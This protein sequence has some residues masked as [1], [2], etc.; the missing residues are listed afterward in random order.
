MPQLKKRAM[1]LA[2]R[3]YSS[4]SKTILVRKTLSRAKDEFAVD[5][6]LKAE[7]AVFVRHPW[8]EPDAGNDG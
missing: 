7:G 3:G 5:T 8:V 4:V 1:K 6:R 2:V